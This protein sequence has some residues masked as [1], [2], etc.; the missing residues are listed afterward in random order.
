MVPN[1]ARL[2][3]PLE[4]GSV[5]AAAFTVVECETCVNVMLDSGKGPFPC[6]KNEGLNDVSWLTLLGLVG[7]LCLY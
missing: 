3:G 5:P 7:Y 2:A 4:S 1:A 6:K